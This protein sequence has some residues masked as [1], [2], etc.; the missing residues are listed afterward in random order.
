MIF[1]YGIQLQIHLV[2]KLDDFAFRTATP[3]VDVP[4]GDDLS[5]IIA[6]PT[7]TSETDGVI[8]TIPVGELAD[9][10]KYVVF[11]N[12]VLDPS[13]YAANPDE[14]KYWF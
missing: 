7:S 12:G 11:A 6:A 3:F 10:E 2:V 4:A 13:S 8:A 9:M 5:V 1:I 14:V